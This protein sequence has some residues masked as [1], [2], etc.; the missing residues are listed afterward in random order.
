MDHSGGASK[1][2]HDCR[3]FLSSI[4]ETLDSKESDGVREHESQ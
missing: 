1:A 3:L 2:C 4:F